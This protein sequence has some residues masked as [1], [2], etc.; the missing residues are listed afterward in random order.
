[1]DSSACMT[2]PLHHW[3]RKFRIKGKIKIETNEKCLIFQ[4]KFH[5]LKYKCTSM[6]PNKFAVNNCGMKTG[7][8]IGS[9]L[10]ELN[11][12]FD[13]CEPLDDINVHAVF[14]YRYAIYRKFPIDL[15]GNFCDI[16][17]PTKKSAFSQK[18]ISLHST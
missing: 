9:N 12:D 13:V 17:K 11:F 7:G 3:W 5:L 4:N 1:M 2:F 18:S 15:W 14:Y 8:R 16:L 6:A 10:I